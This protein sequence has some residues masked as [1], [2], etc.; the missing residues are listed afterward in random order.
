M[1]HIVASLLAP[2]MIL[3]LAS[4]SVLANETSKTNQVVEIRDESGKIIR[5]V[6]KS[7]V[8]VWYVYDHNGVLV[9]E[10][11]ADGRVIRH[12]QTGD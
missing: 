10:R 5:T 11:Y 12:D 3:S 1:N 7:G 2:V 6:D 8:V 9:E 4:G